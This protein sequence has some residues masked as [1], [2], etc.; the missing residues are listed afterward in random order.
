MKVIRLFYLVIIVGMA[1]LLM[2]TI[3]GPS[4]SGSPASH[5]GGPGEQSCAT[6]GCHDDNAINAGNA[7]LSIDFGGAESYKPGKTYK[8]KVRI[9]D[10]NINRF[11]FQLVALKGLNNENAG[12]FKITDVERT[13]LV[14]NR[15]ELLDREYVTYSFHG[16]GATSD[17]VAEW[18]MDWKAPGLNSG[19]VRFYLSGLSANDNENDKGDFVYT[20]SFILNEIK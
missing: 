19:A 1:S 18:T 2:S 4:S 13:Q 3:H 10:A 12:K 9:A 15:K 17:G 7:K 6:A 20:N 5:T 14:Y 8:I 16:T 11:G